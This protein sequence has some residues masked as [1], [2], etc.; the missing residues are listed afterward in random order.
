MAEAHREC[1]DRYTDNDK[2]HR[3]MSSYAVTIREAVVVQEEQHGLE[4][5]KKVAKVLEKEYGMEVF[6][7][8][9]HRNEGKGKAL[10]REGPEDP[11]Q[12]GKTI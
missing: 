6:Q 9:I 10:F 2:R 12:N 8:H 7:V 5:L 1:Q 11:V 4:D 3:K